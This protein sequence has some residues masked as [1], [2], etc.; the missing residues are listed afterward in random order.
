LGGDDNIER[1]EDT[2]VGAAAKTF[3]AAAPLVTFAGNDVYLGRCDSRRTT[4][5]DG[6]AADLIQ[7]LADGVLG[8]PCRA[9]EIV[10]GHSLDDGAQA[11]GRSTNI[12]HR[13][14]NPIASKPMVHRCF[15]F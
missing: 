4:P 8:A 5:G 14:L 7:Q 9:V 10:I 12:D 6:N 13:D 2:R 3:C 15:Q 1:A 11:I